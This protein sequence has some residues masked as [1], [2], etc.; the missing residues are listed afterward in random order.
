MFIV[1]TCAFTTKGSFEEQL[2]C[3]IFNP[4]NVFMWQIEG[5]LLWL[6]LILEHRQGVCV[7][8]V[9]AMA[10]VKAN[11]TCSIWVK[12]E[13]TP[14]KTKNRQMPSISR[15]WTSGSVIE[16]VCKHTHSQAAHILYN[17][18]GACMHIYS[19]VQKSST[20]SCFIHCGSEKMHINLAL[21]IDTKVLF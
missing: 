12:K 13:T 21:H 1:L 15:L 10:V 14:T 3:K 7:R 18:S 8:S 5:G 2:Y 6:S 17:A 9:E 19:R 16:K 4:Q 20:D 11:S